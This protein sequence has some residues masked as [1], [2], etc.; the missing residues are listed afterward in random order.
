MGNKTSLFSKLN[1]ESNSNFYISPLSNRTHFAKSDGQFLSQNT[2]T[3]PKEATL[4]A[5]YKTA[6]IQ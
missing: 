1:T 6:D 5:H 4:L 2:F 3:S